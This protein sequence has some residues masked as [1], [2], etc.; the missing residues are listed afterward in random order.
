MWEFHWKHW[1]KYW[2]ILCRTTAKEKSRRRAD[3][4]TRPFETAALIFRAAVSLRLHKPMTTCRDTVADWRLFCRV[5]FSF[6]QYPWSAPAKK[7]VAPPS[8]LS[9]FGYELYRVSHH[10]YKTFLRP[11][12]PLRLAGRFLLFSEDK[13]A[14]KKIFEKFSKRR[15]LAGSERLCVRLVS[16]KGETHLIPPGK[17]N[18]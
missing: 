17:T 7:S 12:G 3:N 18:Y 4:L 13:P 14:S 8:E 10:L 11:A 1:I 6:S 15:L 5:L 9:G 16:G 2:I